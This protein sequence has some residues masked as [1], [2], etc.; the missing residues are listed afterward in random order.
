MAEGIRFRGRLEFFDPEAGKG[1]TVIEIPSEHVAPLGGRK[2]FR[3]TGTLNGTPFTGSTMA[4]K[5]GSFCVAVSKAAMVSAGLGTG[6]RAE[7][8]LARA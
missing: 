6:D 3:V 7:V 2:Q 8:T 5:G 4:R 1:L